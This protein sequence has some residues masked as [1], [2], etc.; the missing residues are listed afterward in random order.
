MVLLGKSG[1]GVTNLKIMRFN[2]SKNDNGKSGLEVEEAGQPERGNL[3]LYSGF[4]ISALIGAYIGYTNLAGGDGDT[5]D[6][7]NLEVGSEDA[8]G[9]LDAKIAQDSEGLV[10]GDKQELEQG[11]EEGSEPEKLGKEEIRAIIE[12]PIFNELY[13]QEEDLFQIEELESGIEVKLED[14]KEDHIIFLVP[15][16]D[17]RQFLNQLKGQLAG[18]VKLYNTANSSN[19]ANL[20]VQY[21][22]MKSKRDME[23]LE[24]NIQQR[25]DLDGNIPL[26]V[27]KNK[28]M[29]EA[30][31]ITLKDLYTNPDK[32]FLQFKPLKTINKENHNSV[33][34]YFDDMGDQGLLLLNYCDPQ[35]PS[36][37]EVV[38]SFY[39]MA[40]KGWFSDSKQTDL[41]FVQDK[42]FFGDANI[43]IQDGDYL[44][45]KRTT[46]AE[47]NFST[48][49]GHYK[50]LKWGP[51][52][53]A[54][55][56]EE[57]IVKSLGD[58][59]YQNFSFMKGEL[60]T[61]PSDFTVELRIDLNK[62]KDVQVKAI[63]SVVG[64]ARKLIDQQG[65]N[66]S[67]KFFFIPS[68]SPSPNGGLVSLTVR[69]MRKSK[70]LQE[71]MF[72]NKSLEKAEE[73]LKQNPEF[74][75]NDQT[76]K[77][78]LPE[79]AQMTPSN[80]AQ[81]VID[82]VAGK[83]QQTY[84]SQNKPD[85]VRFSRRVCGNDF[86]EQIIKNPINH[87]MMIYSKHCA[88]CKRFSP[89][90]EKLAEENL[91][92]AGLALGQPTMFNRFNSDYNDIKGYK[93]FTNTPVFAVYRNGYKKRP[94]LYKGNVL[95]EKLMKDFFQISLDFKVMDD[96]L[97][98]SLVQ[99][100]QG[101]ADFKE[102]K[103]C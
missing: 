75:K 81:F 25:L 33:K 101:Y 93:N 99:R 97:C 51:D 2:S 91:K 66:S 102:I 71:H 17:D 57:E 14:L 37:Q 98:N 27:I 8:D 12:K 103:L 32:L 26:F 64:Q 85:Y 62:I 84:S 47:S 65:I 34:G 48:D 24:K 53:T 21:I 9:I 18:V 61:G 30:T 36:Y 55:L 70:I 4:F 54:N 31:V 10:L 68:N 15:P 40:V 28:L 49:G 96:Q 16:Q 38:S 67:I 80:I 87:A 74:A 73:V 19:N 76:N 89:V 1:R 59:Y 44:L 46:E 72:E 60:N 77:Y 88:S 78:I 3:M 86:E 23:T 42:E 56:T 5:E 45:V 52:D 39:K 50:V 83:N 41:V 79:S 22:L 69:D 13:L 11:N 94:F 58:I 20:K 29:N 100:I 35:A 43:E 82:S 90:Y 7:G 95:T 92:E 63:K 6:K